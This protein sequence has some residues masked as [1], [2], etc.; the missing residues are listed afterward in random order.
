MGHFGSK[1]ANMGEDFTVRHLI[2]ERNGEK[3]IAC[4]NPRCGRTFRYAEF[5]HGVICN[6]CFKLCPVE[7]KVYR[8]LRRI[9]RYA[10]RY[11]QKFPPERRARLARRLDRN[12]FR[13]CKSFQKPEE[14]VGLD[15]FLREIGLR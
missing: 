4:V 5:P 2:T 7:L 1:M 10:E 8:K 13:I 6:K 11:P 3:R 15:G 12:W 9:W 14:P